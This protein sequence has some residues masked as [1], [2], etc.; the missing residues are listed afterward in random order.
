MTRFKV[1]LASRPSFEISTLLVGASL[2]LATIGCGSEGWSPSSDSAKPPIEESADAL[3]SCSGSVDSVKYSY[4]LHQSWEAYDIQYMDSPN[5]SPS[6]P[7]R[8]PGEYPNGGV[9]YD[10][11][12]CAGEF[13]ANEDG[14]CHT[15]GFRDFMGGDITGYDAHNGYDNSIGPGRMLDEGMG[16]VYPLADGTVTDVIHSP[17]APSEDVVVV[18]HANGY[19]SRYV[20]LAYGS[21]RVRIGDAVTPNTVLATLGIAEGHLHF[22][23]HDC[24]YNGVGEPI[25]ASYYEVYRADKHLF[26][27]APL[28]DSGPSDVVQ[29]QLHRNSQPTGIILDDVRYV[30]G[31]TVQLTAWGQGRPGDVISFEVV[32]QNGGVRPA[33]ATTSYVT[34][35]RWGRFTSTGSMQI[36]GS[37]PVNGWWSARVLINGSQRYQRY[38]F[39]SGSFFPDANGPV[40]STP[41]VVSS[42]SDNMAVFYR[43]ADGNLKNR[44]WTAS[45][46]WG[47][48]I[49]QGGPFLGRPSCVQRSATLV[50]CF[51]QGMNS[52]LWRWASTNGGASGTF[53]EIFTN[54]TVLGDPSALSWSSTSLE[55]IFRLNNNT[56]G[57]MS[58]NGTS[59][60]F[61]PAGSYSLTTPLA[62]LALDANRWRCY[63]RQPADGRLYEVSFASGSQVAATAIP[64]EPN[65]VPV[66][67]AASDNV[68]VA[69][70]P[71]DGDQLN[72]VDVSSRDAS[73]RMIR[74]TRIEYRNRTPLVAWMPHVSVGPF[75]LSMPPTCGVRPG[76]RLFECFAADVDHHLVKNSW[77]GTRWTDWTPIDRASEERFAPSV[78]ASNDSLELFYSPLPRRPPPGFPSLLVVRQTSNQGLW[79]ATSPFS[80]PV[81]QAPGCTARGTSNLDC[82]SVDA[83]GIITRRT[84]NGSSWSSAST[85]A[86]GAAS[87][88]SAVSTSSSSVDI[89]YLTPAGN[90]NWHHLGASGWSGSPTD[91]GVPS[92]R[93]LVD[94]PGCTVWRGTTAL[95]CF[96]RDNAN[97]LM[98]LLRTSAGWSTWTAVSRAYSAPSAVSAASGEVDVFYRG[99]D[100]SLRHMARTSGT[101][102]AEETLA[103]SIASAPSC[104]M[105]LSPKRIDCFAQGFSNVA[106]DLLHYAFQS[107]IGWLPPRA[108]GLGLTNLA[109]NR[110]ATQSSEY[111]PFPGPASRA[112][113]GNVDPNFNDGSVSHTNNSVGPDGNAWWEVDLGAVRNIDHLQVFNRTDCCSE[114][115]N[116]FLVKIRSTATSA[117]TDIDTQRT[118]SAPTGKDKPNVLVTFNR[119]DP[120]FP[121]VAIPIRQQ[122]RYVRI[123]ANHQDYLS[124]AEVMVM[125]RE[126]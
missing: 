84:W 33:S 19:F 63:A 76:T 89:F 61:V 1:R 32:D 70:W 73:S 112:V 4:P 21:Q 79:S 115:L 95:D 90:L 123:Q 107:S 116:G 110:P 17:S 113:D 104:A 36:F 10:Y 124:L 82:F 11:H 43:G 122:A 40:Q 18:K 120:A 35:D 94:A 69:L 67:V 105:R 56:L 62:C 118:Q 117:W 125:G 30:G 9:M 24:A 31:D 68:T 97:N 121:G 14:I 50:D 78:T 103:G 39:V 52:H 58:W 64:N 80:G 42:G 45:A 71:G 87:Q 99:P 29:L 114:R 47:A 53:S 126:F 85:R 77:T 65:G 111:T 109:L 3:M 100:N 25:E 5:W 27:R 2:A 49:N 34:P 13:S 88:I 108:I 91:L 48:E 96:A 101:W 66:D 41:S 28:Y 37:D 55:A 72:R 74:Q 23:F 75:N 20:H 81:F 60:R 7:T 92:G 12:R 102:G 106:Q 22:D 6:D 54:G 86:S 15:L 57:R 98:R 8:P 38:F 16:E 46:G 51:V 44:R 83:T 93:K 26:G 119:T 59:F